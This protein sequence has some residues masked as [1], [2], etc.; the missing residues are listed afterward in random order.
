MSF[1]SIPAAI[2]P[3]WGYRRS[4]C[5]PCFAE[6]CDAVND[7]ACLEKPSSNAKN[8][9]RAERRGKRGFR[10]RPWTR[11]ES[12]HGAIVDAFKLLCL[13]RESTRQKVRQ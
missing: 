2:P 13:A 9:A 8:G 11:R 1:H 4:S 6:G 7:L 10:K 3:S 5:L 12:G